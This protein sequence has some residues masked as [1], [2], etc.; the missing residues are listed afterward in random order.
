MTT[1]HKLV[2]G[3]VVPLSAEEIAQRQQDEIAWNNGAFDRAMADLRIKRDRL[4]AASDWTQLP[5]TTLTN[6][7]KQSWMQY[8]T[9]LRNITDGLKT[10]ADVNGVS[11]PVKPN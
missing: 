1:P 3:Q 7:Q 11:F 4:L 8:R 9:E 5:D 6:T 2:N 10:V